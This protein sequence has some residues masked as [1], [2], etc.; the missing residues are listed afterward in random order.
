MTAANTSAQVGLQEDQHGRQPGQ[1]EGEQ[2]V[3]VPGPDLS[4]PRFAEDHGEQSD[5]PHLGE[6]RRLDLEAAADHDPRVRAVDRGAERAQHGDEADAREAV[7]DRRI[8]PQQPV[9]QD[10]DEAAEHEPD[11][12]VERVPLEEGLRVAA[13]LGQRRPGRRPDQHGTEDRQ[14][15]DR[16]QQRPVQMAQRRLTRRHPARP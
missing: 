14:R 16:E 5:Q 3:A 2:D 4:V 13:L 9:V 12:Q 7:Q 11:R 15:D 6:F 8:R 1:P 10:R